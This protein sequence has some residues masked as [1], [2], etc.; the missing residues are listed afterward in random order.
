MDLANTP[1]PIR[2][3]YVA[4]VLPER[5][6]ELCLLDPFKVT[7]EFTTAWQ[8]LARD[9]CEPNPFFE[10]WFLLSSYKAFQPE[11]VLLAALFCRGELTGVL[12]LA[13]SN[14][15]YG[16]PLPHW[17]TWSHANSFC[18]TPLVRPGYAKRFWRALIAEVEG[19]LG[20]ALFLHLPLLPTEGPLYGALTEVLAEDRR[21]SAIVAREKRALLASSLSADEYLAAS[22]SAKKRK[23]LRRQH[24]RLAEEGQLS[25]ERLEGAEALSHWIEEFLDLEASGWKG[26]AE[27]ALANA[28]QTRSFFSAA[29]QGA[30]HDGRLERLALRIDDRPIAMLANF[31]TPPGTYS[32]KTAFDE[33]YARFSPGMLLQLENLA[34]LNRS[35]IHWSD[36][37]AAE[38]HPMIERLW[39]ERRSLSGLNI[40]LGGPL[41]RTMFHGLMAYETRNRS[42]L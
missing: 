8:A 36:S 34:L 42:A 18:G 31:L 4:G 16:H 39:R 40:A 17:T 33:H 12:P 13:R 22:M 21:A 23:E 38:G 41:R 37:C 27:S 6:D 32:F 11:R 5:H 30:A 10:P 9:T 7:A 19:H 14:C 25:F 29:L 35:D 3:G 26:E 20:S 24:K 15:Y 1:D 2:N 28:A